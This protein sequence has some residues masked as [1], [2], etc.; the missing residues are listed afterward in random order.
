MYFK[1]SVG[2][3]KATKKENNQNIKIEFLVGYIWAKALTQWVDCFNKK[4]R[5]VVFFFQAYLNK[6]VLMKGLS[7]V[8]IYIYF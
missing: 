8:F 7:L 5:T 2:K 4:E 1:F 6:I 3:I